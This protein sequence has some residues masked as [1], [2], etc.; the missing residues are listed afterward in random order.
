MENVKD[1][2]QNRLAT[3][4]G[5]PAFKRARRF[6]KVKTDGR[7]TKCAP[8]T[9]QYSTQTEGE[10]ANDDKF[11]CDIEV[12]TP[13]K[14]HQPVGVGAGRE[15]CRPRTQKEVVKLDLKSARR[16][17]SS[18]LARCLTLGFLVLHLVSHFQDEFLQDLLSPASLEL[19]PRRH[20][21]PS[22][23]V[24]ASLIIG[25]SAIEIQEVD[26]NANTQ[27]LQQDQQRDQHQQQSNQP[28][29][30]PQE[31]HPGD[32]NNNEQQTQQSSEQQRQQGQDP[33]EPSVI[34]GS[35]S[36]QHQELREQDKTSD[37]PRRPEASR[38]PSGPLPPL[39]GKPGEDITDGDQ[40][41]RG[42]HDYDL[43]ELGSRDREH[44]KEVLS[45]VILG[46]RK[47]PENDPDNSALSDGKTITGAVVD[48]ELQPAGGHNKAKIKKKKKKKKMEKKS[49][50]AFKKWGKKKKMEKKAMEKAEKKHMKKKKEEGKKKKKKWGMEEHGQKKKG[51]FKKKKWGKKVK[52]GKGVKKGKKGKKFL[53]DKGHK[54][55]G[56]K[57]VY[58][59]EEW[60]KSAKWHDI[61]RE[62]KWD[63][64]SKKWKKK[65]N[66]EKGKKYKG[67]HMKKF[68]KKKKEG[69]K[70]K[71]AKKEKY[72]KFKKEEFEKGK[73][74]K[75]EEHKKNEQ[76]A[77]DFYS[78]GLGVTCSGILGQEG[79]GRLSLSGVK[80][81]FECVGALFFVRVAFGRVA[82]S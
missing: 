21:G 35:S 62:K 19:G 77:D 51:N 32:K 28:S 61:K 78:M 60:G 57:T 13:P 39:G 55:T 58:H 71:K 29:E 69:K 25:D 82:P 46:T 9:C 72:K 52:K 16:K 59:K 80:V 48:F 24:R 53:K 2:K 33:M 37:Q 74:K 64:K 63:E 6:K 56:F 8:R 36:G 38:L 23:G 66:K 7:A 3:Q 15:T 18:A 20:S 41:S 17:N 76:F 44:E 49:E 47:P 68:E 65:W 1:R 22:A 75:M 73:K 42:N 54:N 14:G 27:S 5:W 30:Q 81:I 11:S 10:D 34:L 67:D 45:E 79:G 50:E 4:V 26:P 12:M 43:N 31:H 40:K 70:Y